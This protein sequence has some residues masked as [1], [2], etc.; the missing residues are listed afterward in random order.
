MN[1]FFTKNL[2]L[3][4]L[5]FVFLSVFSLTATSVQAQKKQRPKILKPQRIEFTGKILLIPHDSRPLAWKLPRLIARVSDYEIVLPPL[6]MLGDATTP[7]AADRIV[8]W[9]EKIDDESIKGAIISLDALSVK[10]ASEQIQKRLEL[11]DRLRERH[12]D[13]PI[14]GFAEQSKNEFSKY[15][16]DD[17]FIGSDA[18]NAAHLMLARFLNRTHQRPPKISTISSAEFPPGVLNVLK[19]KINEIGGESAPTEKADLFLFIHTPNTDE[20]KLENLVDALAKAAATGYYVALVDISGKADV[21]MAKLRERKLL[22]LLQSYSAAKSPGEAFGKVLAQA[23]ARLISAKVLRTTLDTDQLQRLERAQIEL[24][25]T[26][27]LEDWEYGEIIRPKLEAFIR[28][29]LKADPQSLGANTEKAE[30]FVRNEMQ[31]FAGEL[32]N[33]QFKHNLHSV[34]TNNGYRIAFEIEILQRFKIQ[35]PLQKIDAVEIDVGIHLPMLVGLDGAPIR[36]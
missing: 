26:R 6:E 9:A 13:L 30:E 23:S 4:F 17:L 7:P 34:L 32:F 11:I 28:D 20:A 8:E 15:V 36:R 2:A 5:P 18:A 10:G 33:Q 25:F 1:Y 29:N 24:L 14:Y 16:F 21:L 35:F 3:R 22:D 12:R 31:P 19:N 27:Y